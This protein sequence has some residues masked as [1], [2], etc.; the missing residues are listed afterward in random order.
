MRVDPKKHKKF[1]GKEKGK[2]VTHVKLKKALCGTSQAALLFCQKDLSGELASWGFEANPC[3]ECVANKQIN[4]KQCTILW[5]TDNPKTSHA[6]SKVVDE[7]IEK[8]NKRCGKHTPL[9]VTRGKVHECLGMTMDCSQ[10]SK[11]T[12]RMDD[13]V[14][15]TPEEAR[16]DVAGMATSPAADHL[17]NVNEVDPE[18]PAENDAKCFHTMTAKMLFLSKRA[19]PDIQQGVAFLTARVKGP[20]T[21]NHKKLSGVVKHLRADPHLALTLEA[22]DA[23]A[24][25]WWVDASFAAHTD[26]KS[27]TGATMSIGKGSQHLTSTRQ[28][29]NAKSSTEAELV[30]ASDV[31]PMVSWTRCFLLQAQGHK[32]NDTTMHQDNQGAMLL[33][34]N[35]RSSSGKRTRHVNI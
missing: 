32:V 13:C 34:K 3:D 11:A 2:S 23:H 15:G 22:D 10:P 1:L 25:K 14:D 7:I 29:L 6:N 27:H 35:G 26:M 31:V 30:G 17:H 24:V 9:M 19:R 28:K 5:H 4:G 33:E 21:D 16:S 8:L 12:I 18:P 20:N